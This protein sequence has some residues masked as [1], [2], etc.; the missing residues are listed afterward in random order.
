MRTVLNVAI[1][2]FPAVALANDNLPELQQTVSSID[3]VEV[4]ASGTIGQTITGWQLR[5]GGAAYA[6]ELAV[7]RSTLA[8]ISECKFEL[9]RREDDCEVSIKAEVKVSG[10]HVDLLIYEITRLDAET[11]P[12]T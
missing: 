11:T 7:D 1:A 8:S 10:S 5:S 2:I 6:V 4:Q 9:F 12:P 3:G